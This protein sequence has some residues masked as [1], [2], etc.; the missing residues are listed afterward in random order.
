MV[1]CYLPSSPKKKTELQNI[2][3]AI[4]LDQKKL[5]GLK[6]GEINYK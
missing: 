3:F 4:M 2:Q 5:L 6:G 1:S